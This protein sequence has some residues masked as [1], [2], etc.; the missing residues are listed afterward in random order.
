MN[1]IEWI[2]TATSLMIIGCCIVASLYL[3]RDMFIE[4]RKYNERIFAR[5]IPR[6]ERIKVK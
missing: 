3:L 1:N 2:I 6:K 5:R 4:D